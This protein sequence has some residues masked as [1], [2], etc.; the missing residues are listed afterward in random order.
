MTSLSALVDRL[1]PC[2]A[3]VARTL[4]VDARHDALR[5]EIDDILRRK[6]LPA[7]ATEGLVTHREAANLFLAHLETWLARGSDR[8]LPTLHGRFE[9]D[10]RVALFPGDPAAHWS[11]VTEDEPEPR[12]GEAPVGRLRTDRLNLEFSF[13]P[14]ASGRD[15]WFVLA[16]GQR[17]RVS[18]DEA[19]T[20][21][22]VYAEPPDFARACLGLGLKQARGGD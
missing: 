13:G 14:S 2:A 1:L 20:V 10:V 22:S 7:I 12:V 18:L 6:N 4:G 9:R 16:D 11:R 19:E 21:A 8:A 3:E 17:V 15:W 5:A